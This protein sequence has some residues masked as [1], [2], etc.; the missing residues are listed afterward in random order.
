VNDGQDDTIGLNGD[1]IAFNGNTN[2][3]F[4]IY[5]F[6]ATNV[7][8]LFSGYMSI[9]SLE[10]I[11]VSGVTLLPTCRA[12][13]RVLS[14]S[15]NNCSVDNVSGFI[16][17]ATNALGRAM[18]FNGGQTSC[19]NVHF[20]HWNIGGAINVLLTTGAAQNLRF[21]DWNCT[22]FVNP[23]YTNNA[24]MQIG[25]MY[26]TNFT[27]SDVTAVNGGTTNDFIVRSG[28]ATGAGVV[29]FT[30]AN[31]HIFGFNSLLNVNSGFT[32][33]PINK[34]GNSVDIGSHFV[35]VTNV[36]TGSDFVPSQAW[37]DSQRLGS[38][39]Q[40]SF[41]SSSNAVQ[42][43][44]FLAGLYARFGQ[45]QV[46]CVYDFQTNHNAS[47][48]GI[49][50]G[51]KN[52]MTVA[53]TFTQATNGITFV[54]N[55]IA[56]YTSELPAQNISY[57][58]TLYNYGNTAFTAFVVV[59]KPSTAASYQVPLSFGT[60]GVND[61]ILTMIPGNTNDF[62]VGSHLAVGVH[63]SA[64][65]VSAGSYFYACGN[66]AGV[67]SAVAINGG[68]FGSSSG[69]GGMALDSSIVQVGA[70]GASYPWTN[71]IAMVGVIKHAIT[72]PDSQYIYALIKST[73]G[74]GL[75]LP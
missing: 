73:I 74:S 71:G 14:S 10:N 1:E 66:M 69:G 75:S 8:N 57:T 63:N 5:N 42:M 61:A 33:F 41:F 36:G 11:N 72:T 48:G 38:E 2:A 7:T 20:D 17:T 27:V 30:L 53:G 54:T 12:A 68:T 55:S 50:Y 34:F 70:N 13:V 51:A 45:D 22:N 52:L 31:N 37:A 62:Y 46:E 21:S 24:W 6:P 15:I 64:A 43:K 3:N 49:L 25:D 40:G 26:L 59:Q 39:V 58:N 18:I 65:A 29:N 35:G 19:N 67:A 9:G 23:G 44:L 56:Q 16:T 28:A 60:A 47:T 4:F 32:I